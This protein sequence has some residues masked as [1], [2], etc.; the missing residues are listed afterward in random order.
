MGMPA[1]TYLSPEQYLAL[2]RGSEEKHEYLDGDIVAMAGATVAHN[3]IVANLLREVGS[4]LKGTSCK[5]RPGDLRVSIPSITSYTYPDATIICG[6]PEL[7]DDQFDTVKNP[8]V[9]FEVMSRSTKQYDSGNKFLYYQRIASLKEYILID[10]RKLSVVVYRR[11]ADDYWRIETLENI[12][13]RLAIRTIDFQL[14]L[15][16]IYFEVSL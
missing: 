8:S 7:E 12:D 2:E 1:S 14:P 4:F 11:E 3:D 9:I 10:S 5:I 16:D 13:D 6:K 15:A